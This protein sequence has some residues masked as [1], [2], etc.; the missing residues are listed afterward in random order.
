MR[1]TAELESRFLGRPAAD[2]EELGKASRSKG[3]SHRQRGERDEVTDRGI[4]EG[5]G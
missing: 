2:V 1:L 5:E 4:G 3:L